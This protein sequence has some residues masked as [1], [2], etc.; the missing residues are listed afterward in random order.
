MGHAGKSSI[1]EVGENWMVLVIGNIQ[2]RLKRRN[3]LLE[4]LCHI[5]CRV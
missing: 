2:H 5:A 1:V 4:Q 3:R